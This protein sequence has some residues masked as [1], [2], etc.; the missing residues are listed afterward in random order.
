ML[1]L[2]YLIT[3]NYKKFLFCSFVSVILSACSSDDSSATSAEKAPEKSLKEFSNTLL[4]LTSDQQTV[5]EG[6]WKNALS[7]V[8]EGIKK[9]NIAAYGTRLVHRPK[10][11]KPGDAVSEGVGYGMLTA[12]FANDQE[13]FNLI[14][15]AGN[16]YMWSGCYYDWQVNRAGSVI[17]QGAASDAEEDVALALVFA[18]K[19]VKA[20]KWKDYSSPKRGGYLEHAKKIMG[21]MWSTMQITSKGTLAPGAG[22]GGEQFVNPGYFSPA[23]YK[24]FAKYDSAHNWQN[25]VDRS[26]EILSNSVGYPYG[27]IPDWMT[28][29][30]GFAGAGLG[31][32]A[33]G[34][35][36]Y[37]FKDAIRT[38]WR[39]AIDAIWFKDTRAKAL[40]T[41]AV[42]FIN[43]AG[44]APAANFYKTDG[45]LVPAEDVWT[46]MAAGTITRTRREH[47]HL[48]IGMWATAIAA[49]G[50]KEDMEAFSTELS[51]FYEGGDYF[52]NA[53]DPLGGTEDTLHNEMYF[54]QFLGWFGASMLSGSF[55]NVIDAID[56]PAAPG[57]KIYT[58]ISYEEK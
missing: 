6:Y 22:W 23:W 33:Y 19:L 58:D 45:T 5:D 38:L 9:R 24:I 28:P 27:L 30:G 26:Y 47:S 12:M 20:G 8:W 55:I 17:G 32:N 56:N 1:K 44:G 14:W 25:V 2:F 35:G 11:E 18:D 21:C 34:D 37:C 16:T 36:L 7:N 40:L 51:K 49:A 48:T 10:S 46:D 15:E 50:S 13:T 41:N 3:M 53:V 42:A 39:I 43:N 57:E 54:D 52:G 4:D 31:Y 29:A